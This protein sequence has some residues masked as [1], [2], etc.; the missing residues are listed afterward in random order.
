MTKDVLHQMLG[1]TKETLG[2][3]RQERKRV[4]STWESPKSHRA[5]RES[6][7]FPT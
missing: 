5:S 1:G 4:I 6:S 7:L 3:A 2:S